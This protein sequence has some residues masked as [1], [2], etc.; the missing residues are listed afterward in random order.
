MSY[1]K[2]IIEKV[3]KTIMVEEQTGI[4][5][6]LTNEE[7][8]FLV[9]VLGSLPGDDAYTEAGRIAQRLYNVLEVFAPT[10]LDRTWGSKGNLELFEKPVKS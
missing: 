5:W 9:V 10:Y 8:D 7:A 2:P 3:E 4:E 1:A 6:H